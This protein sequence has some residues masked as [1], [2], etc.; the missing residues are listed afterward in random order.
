M[1]SFTG[2]GRAFYKSGQIIE[3]TNLV[4]GQRHGLRRTWR[5]DGQLDYEG[6]WVND[7]ER[8]SVR[9]RWGNN[10]KLDLETSYVNGVRHGLNRRWRYG[11]L[12]EETS[13]VNGLR[14]G[15]NRTWD[16]YGEEYNFSPQCWRDHIEV[17]DWRE[18]D[19]CP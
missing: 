19:A 5:S 3:E 12:W 7:V 1:C 4:D 6:N 15:L 8:D 18:G 2:I 11:L 13:Y 17:S 10:G 14:H 16:E 9:R